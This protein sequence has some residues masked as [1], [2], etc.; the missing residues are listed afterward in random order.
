MPSEGYPQRTMCIKIRISPSLPR[1]ALQN[2]AA[3]W[4]VRLG[5][6]MLTILLVSFLYREGL[7]TGQP[8][9]EDIND[10]M[11]FIELTNHM[12]KYTDFIPFCQVLS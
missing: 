2:L 12:D 8:E 9:N 6:R 7:L 1:Y 5:L 10:V 11:S 3:N 4:I